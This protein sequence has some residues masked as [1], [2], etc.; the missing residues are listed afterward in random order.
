MSFNLQFPTCL[1][2]FLIKYDCNALLWHRRFGHLS[3]HKLQSLSLISSS[4]NI[5]PC[6]VCAKAKQHKIPFPKNVTITDTLFVTIHV[7]VWAPYKHI[8]HD[9]YKYFIIIIDDY[10]KHTWVHL[11]NK[12][13]MLLH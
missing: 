2:M 12:K 9:G 6:Y 4:H 3:F 13:F 7:D 10:S 5:D 11:M 1:N 8:F